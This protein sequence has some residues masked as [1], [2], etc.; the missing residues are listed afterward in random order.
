[1]WDRL[2]AQLKKNISNNNPSAPVL[3]IEYADEPSSLLRAHDT[4]Q[5]SNCIVPAN[6]NGLRKAESVFS[7]SS[8]HYASSNGISNSP[9]R[10]VYCCFLRLWP[11]SLS[12]QDI[13]G[14]L[15]TDY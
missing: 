3:E 4:S 6:T 13:S 8:I 15:Y 11:V 2:A 9:I 5:S 12:L 7:G 14:K 1:M 10:F